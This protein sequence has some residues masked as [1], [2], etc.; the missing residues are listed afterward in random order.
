MTDTQSVY[1][2]AF[3]EEATEIV[4]R[5][6]LPYGRERYRLYSI[7][8]LSLLL[9]PL[10]IFG[11][12]SIPY[13]QQ[14]LFIENLKDR[15]AYIQAVTTRP[16]WLPRFTEEHRPDDGWFQ[17]IWNIDLSEVDI[18]D[19]EL[20]RIAQSPRLN[21]VTLSSESFTKEGIESLLDAPRLKTLQFNACPQISYSLIENYRNEN[22]N[23]KLIW[24]PTVYLGFRASN[25]NSFLVVDWITYESSAVKEGIRHYD[26]VT[27]V[28]EQ[29][30]DSSS[31][32]QMALKNKKPG[33]RVTV[34]ILRDNK[35]MQ[36]Q[37]VLM[38]RRKIRNRF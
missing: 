11:M 35:P 3:E 38:D 2:D 33:D 36:F 30:V 6:L 29:N 16:F 22:P 15:G 27:K 1:L 7:I 19:E 12:L 9:T 24:T 4:E 21:S 34:D 13:V 23:I 14:N 31:S 5:P 10:C 25:Y 8:F 20:K 17:T 37:V 26:V 18:S 28:N 32:I